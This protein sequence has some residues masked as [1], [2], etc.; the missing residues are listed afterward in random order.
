MKPGVTHAWNP[1][2]ET[3][4][5]PYVTLA[6]RNAF[7]SGG[8]PPHSKTWW[9]SGGHHIL[10]LRYGVRRCSAAFPRDGKERVAHVKTYLTPN[11]CA[12]RALIR[13]RLRQL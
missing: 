1:R 10:R 5:S 12:L 3:T 6:P 9:T 13:R 11:R 8:A 4:R 7:Q 2:A